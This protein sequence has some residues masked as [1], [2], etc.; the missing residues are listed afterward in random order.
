MTGQSADRFKP[1]A[2]LA[3]A[4]TGIGLRA[5]H[6]DAVLSDRPPVGFLEVHS[7]NYF[8]IGGG[9][10]QQL[11]RLRE[12]Y[13]LSLHGVG[14]SL[15]SADGLDPEHLEN[16][17]KLAAHFEP[18]LVSEHLSWSGVGGRRVPDLL[19]LP[20]TEEALGVIAMNIEQAQD[21]L[22]RAILIENPSAYMSFAEQGM[23]EPEFLTALAE[24]TGCGL[25]LDINNIHVSAHNTGAFDPEAYLAA[26]PADAVGEI[27]LAGYQVNAVEGGEIFI[28]AHNN[29]VYPEVWKLYEKTLAII[30]DTPTLVEWDNDLPEL[31]ALV[32]EARKADAYRK[33]V[34]ARRMRHAGTA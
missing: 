6:V 23:S 7:E 31:R 15:G 34:A 22:G 33:D 10:F 25:L 1:P 20:L 3:N 27:H 30:G 29:P 9:P 17:A 21:R 2:A 28:D 24:R 13:P 4:P 16:L 26:I 32:K 18:A 5:P 8:A 14:L 11:E 12:L 19:P